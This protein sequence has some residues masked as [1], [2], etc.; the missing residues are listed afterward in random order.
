MNKNRLKQNKQ[1]KNQLKTYKMKKLFLF[2]TLLAFFSCK[3]EDSIHKSI[4]TISSASQA[5]ITHIFKQYL[6]DSGVV[7]N[8][9]TGD[10]VYFNG[11]AE[12]SGNQVLL[13][14]ILS[15]T[16]QIHFENVQGVGLPSGAKYVCIS[17][18]TNNFKLQLTGDNTYQTLNQTITDRTMWVS[19]AGNMTDVFLLHLT[20][21]ANG[22]ITSNSI[23]STFGSCQ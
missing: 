5:Q 18:F 22:D 1:N 12:L 16:Y 3:K 7:Y 19:S 10:S 6:L 13:G 17:H 14:N 4:D 2:L 11:Y 21:N 23:T 8:P 9:C 20:T 15:T